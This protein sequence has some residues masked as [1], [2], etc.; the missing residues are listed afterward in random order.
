MEFIN[1]NSNQIKKNFFKANLFFLFF[2]LISTFQFIYIPILE[3]QSIEAGVARLNTVHLQLHLKYGSFAEEYPEQLMTAMFLHPDAKVLELGGNI[4]RNSCV[5]GA[6]LNDSRNLVSVESCEADARLLQENRDINNLHFYIEAAAISKVPLIQFGWLT[7][8]SEIDQ[9]GWTRVKTVT[10]DEV[11]RKYGI[12]FDTLVADCEGALYYILRDDP[13]MLNNINTIIIEND[14][15][16]IENMLY[17]HNIF[18]SYG[19]RCVYNQAG[20]MGPCVANFYQVWI[21]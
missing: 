21:K 15:G 17:V 11:Q 8:P 14:F 20:G 4:G 19:L 5:I 10:F 3:A 13:N 12:V 18:T 9:P 2:I 16:D 7:I 1:Q 6:L